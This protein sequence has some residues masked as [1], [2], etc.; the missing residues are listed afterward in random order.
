MPDPVR[1]V[2]STDFS[3]FEENNPNT[4]KSGVQLDVQFMDLQTSTTSLRDAILDIRRSDGALKNGIVTEDSLASGLVAALTAQTGAD[5]VNAAVLVA[6][7]HADDA[8]D[9]AFDAVQAANAL[10]DIKAL[11]ESGGLWTDYGSITETATSSSDYGSI[12]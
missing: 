11:L 3:A 2:F 1:F 12:A 9:A 8:E 5:A 6:E 10:E 4:P 7:G